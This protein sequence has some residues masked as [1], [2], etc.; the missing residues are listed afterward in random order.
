MPEMWRMY[1]HADGDRLTHVGTY[2][3]V[4]LYGL[5]PIVPV[6]V[7]EVDESAATHWGWIPTGETDPVMIHDW[8]TAFSACF[9]YGYE[10]EVQ[11]GRGRV[12]RLAV[13]KAD[14]DE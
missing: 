7:R 8:L 3:Y 6:D 12:A 1:A 9:T 4:E 14:D 11:K 13:T 5:R 10:M 2:Q